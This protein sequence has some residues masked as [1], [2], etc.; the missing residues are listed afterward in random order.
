MPDS[1]PDGSES[2]ILDAVTGVLRHPGRWRPGLAA[3]LVTVAVTVGL[4]IGVLLFHGRTSATGTANNARPFNNAF[5]GCAAA[6]GQPTPPPVTE[7]TNIVEYKVPGLGGIERLTTGPDGNLWFVGGGGGPSGFTEVVGR[8][9]PAGKIT[10]YHPPGN[11]GM[12][13]DGI[14]AGP[15]GNVWFTEST[16]DTIGRLVPATGRID[17]FHVSLPPP[18]PSAP[19]RKHAS[20]RHCGRS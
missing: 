19:P 17:S 4:A 15:D 1:L 18:P 5:S 6:P 9:T 2:R 7:T 16:A 11:P 20:H 10:L 8:I 14:T 13:F 3:V 12:A